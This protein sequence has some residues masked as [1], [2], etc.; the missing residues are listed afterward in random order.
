[1][2]TMKRSRPGRGRS[3]IPFSYLSSDVVV[4]VILSISNDNYSNNQTVNLP[5]LRH[6]I[7]YSTILYNVGRCCCFKSQVIIAIL[8]LELNPGLEQ[9]E[10]HS[11]GHRALREQS[12]N[13]NPDLPDSKSCVLSTALPQC[14]VL[15]HCSTIVLS[16][17]I[18]KSTYSHLTTWQIYTALFNLF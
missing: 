9:F 16:S 7:F 12:L 5:Q 4:V 13:V 1:M 18:C 3:N 11:Q 17:V 8:T 2:R 14:S 6:C 10:Q 15:N